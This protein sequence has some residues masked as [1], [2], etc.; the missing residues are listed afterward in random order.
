[1]P[2]TG[3]AFTVKPVS[4]SGWYHRYVPNYYCGDMLAPLHPALFPYHQPSFWLFLLSCPAECLH[5]W[6]AEVEGSIFDFL[7]IQVS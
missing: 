1:M 3:T 7:E 2:G 5:C 6:W 4:S